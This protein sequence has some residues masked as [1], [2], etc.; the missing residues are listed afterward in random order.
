MLPTRS[1][2]PLSLLTAT[3]ALGWTQEGG[4]NVTFDA[5]GPAGFKIHGGS[6][7]VAVADDG[8][9]FKITVKLEE[10]D[11]DN[12]LR[13]RHMLEDTQAKDFPLVTLSVP[14]ASLKESGGPIEATGTLELH[15]QKKDVKFTYTPQCTGNTCEIDGSAPINLGDFGIKIRSY[16]GVT[17]KPD[18]TVGAKF[19]VKK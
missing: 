1:L 2:L 18:I 14:T 15:G 12:G 11:T 17:V 13:N 9:S 3:L 6:D 16:L 5:K 10:V 7:K 4:G 19:K 8:K